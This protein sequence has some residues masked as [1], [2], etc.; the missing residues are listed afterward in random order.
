MSRRGQLLC[1]LACFARDR[2]RRSRRSAGRPSAMHRSRGSSGTPGHRPARAAGLPPAGRVPTAAANSGN[3]AFARVGFEVCP[4]GRQAAAGRPLPAGC[5]AEGELPGWRASRT[6]RGGEERRPIASFHSQSRRPRVRTW[7]LPR[8][9]HALH[10]RGSPGNAKEPTTRQ[11]PRTSYRNRMRTHERWTTPR[12]RRSTRNPL[13][14][15]QNRRGGAG[16]ARVF[17]RRGL[18]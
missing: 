10:V 8:R 13:I 12:I 15:E 6:F 3:Y 11:L 18:L 1:W 2:H 17:E 16:S 14:L 7:A 4:A 5:L 9:R